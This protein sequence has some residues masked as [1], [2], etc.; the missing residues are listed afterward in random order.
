MLSQIADVAVKATLKHGQ[1][2][3]IDWRGGKRRYKGSKSVDGPSVRVQVTSRRVIPSLLANASVAVGDGYVRGHVKIDEDE[4]KEF[5]ELVA[6]NSS[7]VKAR[8]PFKRASTRIR[9][10]RRN[11]A[12]H[13]D[14]GNDYYRLW[15]DKKTQFYS[16]AYF[17]RD[18]LSPEEARATMSL[19]EAQV[20]KVGH[21]LRKL[22]LAKPEDN[23]GR[24]MRLLD[25]GCGWGYLAVTAAKEYGAEVLGITL[26]EEQLKGAEELARREGVSHLVTFKL[27]DYRKLKGE[28]FDRIISV[29][30]YEHVGRKEQRRY[31]EKVSELL[32]DGGV[33]VLHTITQQYPKPVSAWVDKRIFPG[34]YLPTPGEI[35]EVARDKGLWQEDF[36]DLHEH[37]ARTLEIWRERHRQSRTEIVAMYDEE[38][39][40]MRDFWLVGSWAGF[41]LGTLGLAQVVFTKGKSQRLQSRRHVYS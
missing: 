4:L 15:L 34:G 26:S 31:F 35:F 10:Q 40:R 17:E 7:Q 5:F 39:Y 12:H 2:E 13:Y 25:I 19:E 16:C 18:S 37:Y 38:F 24:R 36:E 32:V 1:V 33:T 8:Q 30:M 11:I 20:A 29:G 6:R 23:G 27:M 21:L 14:V 3:L 22:R 41:H 9:R 28:S